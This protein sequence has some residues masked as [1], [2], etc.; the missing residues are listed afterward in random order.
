[1]PELWME[2]RP[3]AADAAPPP[4]HAGSGGRVLDH[5]LDVEMWFQAGAYSKLSL[6]EPPPTA[7]QPTADGRRQSFL[8]RIHCKVRRALKR[9]A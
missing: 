2:F 9:A 8:K 4:V 6:A 1:M 3:A 7:A 5:L